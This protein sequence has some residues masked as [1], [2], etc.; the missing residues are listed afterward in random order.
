MKV[1][2]HAYSETAKPHRFLT[3]CS[4]NPESQPTPGVA[5]A[6]WE[7]TSRPVKHSVEMPQALHQKI[8]SMKVYVRFNDI[9]KGSAQ[10][11][12]MHFKE[13]IGSLLDTNKRPIISGPLSTLNRGFEHFSRLLALHNWLHD[14]WSSVAVISIDNFDTFWKQSLFIR[15]MGSTQIMWVP[16]SFHSIIRLH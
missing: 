6:R 16:G 12:K 11:L 5:R 7:R 14:Y 1:E 4:L 10:Q 3:H 9:M 15:R 8:E 2:S 13:V